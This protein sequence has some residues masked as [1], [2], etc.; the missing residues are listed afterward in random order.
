MDKYCGEISQG[1]SLSRLVGF[2]A[3]G[4]LRASFLGIE[5]KRRLP[6][7]ADNAQS[8]WATFCG[9]RTEVRRFKTLETKP[10]KA[11]IERWQRGYRDVLAY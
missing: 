2:L 4:N 5:K 9:K 3:I 10:K 11:G 6:D 7:E 8:R 1:F